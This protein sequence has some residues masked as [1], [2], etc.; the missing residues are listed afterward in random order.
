MG[1]LTKGTPLS[2]AETVPY[3]KYIKAS[4]RR[5]I[6]NERRIVKENNEDDGL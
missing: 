5:L 2:W 1:L 4:D 3:V 6:M